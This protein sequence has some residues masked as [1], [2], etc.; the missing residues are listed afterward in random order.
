[1]IDGKFEEELS[2]D[3][4]KRKPTNESLTCHVEKRGI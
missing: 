4:T 1:M 3:V 2:L